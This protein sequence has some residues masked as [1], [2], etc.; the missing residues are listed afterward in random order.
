MASRKQH[1]RIREPPMNMFAHHL[2]AGIEARTAPVRGASR[3][4]RRRNGT[5]FLQLRARAQVD[6]MDA[7]NQR[8]GA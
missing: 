6:R 3:R 4:T 5:R 7:R 2:T 8:P 1:E